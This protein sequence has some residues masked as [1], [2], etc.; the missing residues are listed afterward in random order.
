MTEQ[1]QQALIDAINKK[2]EE[3]MQR[4]W[5]TCESL[6]ESYDVTMR[7]FTQAVIMEL[8]DLAKL[9][10]VTLDAEVQQF[11]EIIKMSLKHKCAT[12]IQMVPTD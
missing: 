1:E 12:I 2:N 9:K 10:G 5:Q 11:C 3:L 6:D 4:I 8:L 7:C